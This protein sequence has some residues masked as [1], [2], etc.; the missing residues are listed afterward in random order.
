M[1]PQQM[2]LAAGTRTRNGALTRRVAPARVNPREYRPV[3]SPARH[4]RK[5]VDCPNSASSG[6]IRIC[7]A[8]GRSAS[9][10]CRRPRK[11]PGTKMFCKS[12]E[13]GRHFKWHVLKRHLRV[14]V[15]SAQPRSRSLRRVETWIRINNLVH[16]SNNQAVAHEPSAARSRLVL[17][18]L[19]SRGPYLA[20]VIC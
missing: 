13:F 12:M 20:L 2:I 11:V 7:A 14:R 9:V 3:F 10:S 17:V 15:L 6:S 5:R 1:S 4:A 19:S 8:N 18:A 16:C